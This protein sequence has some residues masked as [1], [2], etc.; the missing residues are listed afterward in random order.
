VISS[1]TARS[2]LRECS[3]DLERKSIEPIALRYD[4]GVWG[5]QLFMENSPFDDL[6]MAQIYKSGV[7]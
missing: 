1:E 4:V 3:L 6:R 7:Y 5:M 2:S